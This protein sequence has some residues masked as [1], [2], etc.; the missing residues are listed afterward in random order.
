M[1]Y[2]CILLVSAYPM[3]P[4]P[5][6]NTPVGWHQVGDVLYLPRGTV[7]Q[8]AAQQEAST[9]L[10]ISTYQNF[11]LG[12]LAQ[13]VL[14]SAMQAQQE[15][16]CLPLSLRRSL[17]PG[18]LYSYGYQVSFTAVCCKSS[19]LHCVTPRAASV[20]EAPVMTPT[21]FYGRLFFP[22]VTVCDWCVVGSVHNECLC[23][24]GAT[25]VHVLSWYM[26]GACTNVHAGGASWY[27]GVVAAAAAQPLV[28]SGARSPHGCTCCPHRHRHRHRQGQTAS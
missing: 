1:T 9:H 3:S 15:P 27:G 11:S 8:A 6:P 22:F 5:A 17:P 10:T 18:F 20:P 24:L 7:H 21:G 2:C 23:L 28:A 14:H 13:A 16:V 12:T 4:L 19:V 26:L 25:C